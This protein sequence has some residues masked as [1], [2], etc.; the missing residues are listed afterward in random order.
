MKK[1][2][3]GICIGVCMMIIYSFVTPPYSGNNRDVSIE[4][5]KEDIISELTILKI[6]IPGKNPVFVLR[7][8]R[9]GGICTL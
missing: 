6:T 8:T 1:L 2:L 4:I 7:D 5:I 9:N 3:L